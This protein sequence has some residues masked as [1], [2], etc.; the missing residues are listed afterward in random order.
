[1]NLGNKIKAGNANWSFN[2]NV[3]K[4]ISKHI[5]S[6]VPFYDEGHNICVELSIFSQ[7]GNQIVMI[8]VVQLEH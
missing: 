2:K 1:M 4:M 5:K 8:L 7:E 3:P 6:S